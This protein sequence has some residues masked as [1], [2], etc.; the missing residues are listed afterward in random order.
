MKVK[1]RWE[2]YLRHRSGEEQLL[3][4][5]ISTLDFNEKP[6]VGQAIKHIRVEMR[7]FHDEIIKVTDIKQ[8]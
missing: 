2:K 6:S 7:C 8:V 3:L 4:C 5:G 1:I